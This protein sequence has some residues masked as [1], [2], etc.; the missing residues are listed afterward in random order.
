MDRMI[1]SRNTIKN[2]SNRDD[3]SLEKNLVTMK[4]EALFIGSCVRAASSLLL[5]A[6]MLSRAGTINLVE[7]REPAKKGFQIQLNSNL[8]LFKFSIKRFKSNSKE[9]E[10]EREK[11]K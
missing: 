4:T 3:W 6:G 10:R 8:S 7:S 9:R 5:A 11:Q 1:R 2:I